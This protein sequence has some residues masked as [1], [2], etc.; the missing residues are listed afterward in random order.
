[1]NADSCCAGSNTAVSGRRG[2]RGSKVGSKYKGLKGEHER[3]IPPL[4]ASAVES[5]LPEGVNAVYEVVI[6]GLDLASVERA[7]WEGMQVATKCPGVKRITAGNYGGKLG[8]FHIHLA[9]LIEG[10][11]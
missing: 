5:Q 11:R 8:P 3:C 7:T 10:K 4:R 2:A 6:D 1:M 9:K